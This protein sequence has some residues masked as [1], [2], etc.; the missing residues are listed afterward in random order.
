MEIINSG[1]FLNPCKVVGFFLNVRDGEVFLNE[2]DVL[3]E[4]S[5][6]FL[7]ER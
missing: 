7:R 4:K 2:I 1:F 6:G 3:S 5:S